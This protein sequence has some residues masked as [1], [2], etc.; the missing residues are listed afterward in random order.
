LTNDTQAS[1][2]NYIIDFDSR[3]PPAR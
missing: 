2:I 1:D 3:Y